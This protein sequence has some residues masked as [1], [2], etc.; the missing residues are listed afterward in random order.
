MIETIQQNLKRA[1]TR[2]LEWSGIV[3]QRVKVELAVI[4]IIQE[5]RKIDENIEENYKMMGRR[6]FELKE[7]HEKNI[8]RDEEI[9]KCLTEIQRLVQEKE[10]L[11]KKASEIT[12]IGSQK[13]DAG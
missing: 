5:I 2:F 4:G 9:I 7:R 3:S 8:L 10:A 6:F 1:W 12:E 11:L 13:P